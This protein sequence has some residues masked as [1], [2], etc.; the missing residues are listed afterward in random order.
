MVTAAVVGTGF[1]GPVH[2]EAL[3]RLDVRVRGILGSSPEKS[4]QAAQKIGLEVGYDDYDA[5]LNDDA[6]DVVHITTPNRY[7]F[8]MAKRAILRGKHVVCEKPLAMNTAETAELVKLAADHP[9]IVAAVNYNIRFYPIVQHAR[10]LIQSGALG[11]VYS[12]RGGYIQDWLLFD[13]D[14]NWR[15]QPDEGGEL[16][17]MGDIG[18]HWMDLIGFVT[19][20]RVESL[21]ADLATF[22][23][24]RK[25]PLQAVATFEGKKEANIPVEYAEVPITTED[26]GAVLFRYA[27]GARGTLNV[28]QVTAGRKNSL[29]FEI[30]GSKGALA[31]D[32]ERP[33][34]LW[35][36]HRDRPSEILLKDPSLL[37]GDAPRFTDYPGGHNEGFPDTFKMLYRA[38]YGYLAAG[39]FSAPKPFPTFAEGH[40]E[41]ALCE[42]I[43]NS[44]KGRAWVSINA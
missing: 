32:S 22:I 10:A 25:K 26:W 24:V 31:W 9:Q 7:H 16:R 15:L 40:Y 35:I 30:A 13:T 18:T 20:L 43:A 37:E 8:D 6:V 14:W 38:V 34:E 17:A 3:Q 21:L 23:P 4:R 12:V 29:T 2:A 33:N 42:A 44:N 28:S 11:D 27:G 19:G 41:V 39:D 36:G 1:I 5:I